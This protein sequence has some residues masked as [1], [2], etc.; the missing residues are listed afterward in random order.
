MVMFGYVLLN[1]ATSSFHCL[2]SAFLAAGGMQSMV[3]VSLVFGSSGVAASAVEPG[4]GS[5][6]PLLLVPQAAS[7]SRVRAETNVT[8]VRLRRGVLN[9]QLL[10]GDPFRPCPTW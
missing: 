6:S 10:I 4:A 8:A 7:E 2:S 1:V 5:W 3:S 9:P